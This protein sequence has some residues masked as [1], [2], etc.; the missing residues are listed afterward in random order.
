MQTKYKGKII[1]KTSIDLIT[2]VIKWCKYF[3]KP[4]SLYLIFK[5]DYLLYID[6][7]VDKCIMPFALLTKYHKKIAQNEVPN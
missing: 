6:H 4:D 5:T 1:I 3:Y 2:W 7:R